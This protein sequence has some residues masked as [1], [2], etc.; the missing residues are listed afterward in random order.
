MSSKYF[1]TAINQ[2]G[3]AADTIQVTLLV[4]DCKVFIPN[5][6]TP[7]HD[8]KNDVFK[9]RFN[10]TEFSGELKVYNR[11]GQLLFDSTDPDYGWDGTY[12][13]KPAAEGIYLY[14]MN[15]KG[16]D[17]GRYVNETLRKTFLLLR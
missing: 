10:C 1:V 9:F 7:N 12:K 15:Y 13:D 17:N 4:C 14:E 11:I 8:A 6:F 2:C 5:A 16:Y 3:V